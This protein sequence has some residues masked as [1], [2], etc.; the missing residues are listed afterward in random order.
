MIPDF[1]AVWEPLIFEKLSIP[2]L[3][4][5]NSPPGKSSFGND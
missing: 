4:P 3:S 2:A 1:I 5:I